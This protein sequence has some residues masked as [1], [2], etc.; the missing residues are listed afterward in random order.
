MFAATL[1]FHSFALLQF[2][3][4]FR[5]SL[6]NSARPQ[7]FC[8]AFLIRFSICLNSLLNL[9]DSDLASVLQQHTVSVERVEIDIIRKLTIHS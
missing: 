8:F 3:L 2:C 5:N 1:D 9:L 4:N 7:Q 6:C